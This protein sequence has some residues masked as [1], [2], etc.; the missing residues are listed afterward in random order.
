MSFDCRNMCLKSFDVCP[1]CHSSRIKRNGKGHGHQRW[2]CKDCCRSLSSRTGTILD[3]SKLKPVQ[4]RRMISMLSDGVLFHQ[5]A[6][7]LRVSV[8]TVCLWKRKLQAL[9]KFQENTMLSGRI[10]ADHTYVRVPEKERSKAKERGLSDNLRQIAVAIDASERMP[11]V[12]G[13][14]GNA[15][16][17]DSS[18]AFSAHIAKGSAVVHDKGDI[19]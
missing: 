14:K 19:L 10:C 1:C 12:L 3:S 13:G 7:Q 8:Q 18:R 11:A 17:E 15:G 4:T 16:S 5:V 2:Y 9:A 6:H